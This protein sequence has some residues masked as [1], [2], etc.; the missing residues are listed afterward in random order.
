[1][2]LGWCEYVEVCVEICSLFVP[3]KW[4]VADENMGFTQMCEVY[5]SDCVLVYLRQQDKA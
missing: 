4:Y 2:V 1:M 5:F 3:V